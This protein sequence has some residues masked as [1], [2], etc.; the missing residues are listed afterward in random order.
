MDGVGSYTCN[1]VTGYI[2]TT[3]EQGIY[4]NAKIDFRHS[5][6]NIRYLTSENE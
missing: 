5:F 2:G 1:C 4:M 6:T 3:C